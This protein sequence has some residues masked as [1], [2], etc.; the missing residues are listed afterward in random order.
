MLSSI[1]VPCK[2][3]SLGVCFIKNIEKYAL[4]FVN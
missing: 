1:P 4:D 2:I 3:L